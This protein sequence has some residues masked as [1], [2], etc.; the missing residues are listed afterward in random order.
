MFFLG[1]TRTRSTTYDASTCAG[2]SQKAK[3]PAVDTAGDFSWKR[4]EKYE[5]AFQKDANGVLSGGFQQRLRE[6]LEEERGRSR[7]LACGVCRLFCVVCCVSRGVCSVC[8][9]CVS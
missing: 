4:E 3:A 8:C 6:A 2:A 1:R 5:G 9:V 7:L